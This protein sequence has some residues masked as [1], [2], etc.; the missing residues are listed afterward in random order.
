[1]LIDAEADP[2]FEFR[3]LG[4]DSQSAA[5]LWCRD[6]FLDE[7]AREGRVRPKTSAL[8]T[9][10]RA[11]AGAGSGTPTRARAALSA[12]AIRREYSH[13]HAALAHGDVPRRS[14]GRIVYV[15]AR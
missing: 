5:R 13:A 6:S 11:T 14:L 7:N 12:E 15:K 8:F 2:D 1:V 4:A 10:A 3:A 9:S